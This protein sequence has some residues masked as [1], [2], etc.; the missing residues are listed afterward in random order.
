MNSKCTA[1]TFT[2]DSKSLVTHG[3]KYKYYFY[4]LLSMLFFIHCII[5]IIYFI[6]DSEEI[7][8]WDLNSRLCVHKAVDDGCISSR[9]ITI[10]SSG[11]FLATG[12]KQGVVNIYETSSVLQSRY[13]KP[14]KIILNLVTP[15]TSLK[16][17]PTSEILAM[18]SEYKENAF[19]MVHLP[20][21]T[22]FSNFPTSR[23]TMHHALS[24]DFSPGSA[25]LGISNNKGNAYL[26][27]L[28]HYGNY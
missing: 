24:I 13:P 2:P 14:L 8:V 28:K 15:I 3:G 17:N 12:S 1:M 6:V 5:N 4:Y 21:L 11:Q 16:F 9:E 27:R 23:T 22:V 20:S 26:Y 25:Y 18:A 7:Y 10:S 19:K